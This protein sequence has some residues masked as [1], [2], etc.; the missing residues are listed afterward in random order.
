[1][2]IQN[3]LLEGVN[4]NH[5]K[6]PNFSGLV[7]GGKPDTIVIHYTAGSSTESSIRTLCNPAAKA[8]AH[9]VVGRDGQTTQLVPFNTIAWHAGRSSYRGRSGLNKYSIGIE[10]DNAGRLTKGP[11]GYTSWFGS[12]Y[13]DKDV[14]EAIHR[15]ENVPSYWHRYPEDQINMVLELCYL[16]AETYP[17]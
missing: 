4:I 9:L 5:K 15:N 7:D 17:I 3:D 2:Q 13:L 6:S 1:M 11:G 8:S 12:I 10:I 14:I 16:L